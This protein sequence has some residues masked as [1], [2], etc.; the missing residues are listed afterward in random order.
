M[1]TEV[2]QVKLYTCKYRK[3]DAGKPLPRVLK[4]SRKNIYKKGSQ[5]QEKPLQWLPLHSKK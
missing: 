4:E 1:Q 5:R 2:K 3:L